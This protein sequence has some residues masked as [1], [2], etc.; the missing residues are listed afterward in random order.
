LDY[1]NFTAE[2]E[3]TNE[4]PFPINSVYDL[5]IITPLTYEKNLTKLVAHKNNYGVKTKITTLEEIYETYTGLDHAE[6]IKYFIKMQ[7]KNGV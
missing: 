4:S 5:V 3:I 1:I 6:Q 7:L 2:Y